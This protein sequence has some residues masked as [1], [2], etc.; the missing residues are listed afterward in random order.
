MCTETIDFK[1]GTKTM[2]KSDREFMKI[3]KNSVRLTDDGHY[4]MKLPLKDPN[5]ALPSNKL[6]VS[7]RLDSL[8]RKF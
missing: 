5:L 3:M 6:Q 4:E 1:A 7:D 2:S 8:K